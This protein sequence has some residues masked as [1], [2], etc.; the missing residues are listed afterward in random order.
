MDIASS[1]VLVRRLG[2]ADLNG[3]ASRAQESYDAILKM[4]ERLKGERDAKDSDVRTSSF[5]SRIFNR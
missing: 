2:G 3:S 1:K 5:R 4:Q